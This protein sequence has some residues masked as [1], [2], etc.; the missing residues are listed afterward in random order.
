MRSR[1]MTLWKL[2]LMSIIAPK[3]SLHWL[4][5]PSAMDL[6]AIPCVDLDMTPERIPK[7]D[8]QSTF[9]VG[10]VLVAWLTPFTAFKEFTSET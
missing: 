9:S 7:H 4:V 6:G 3:S 2:S 10:F 5:T 8:C 1:S